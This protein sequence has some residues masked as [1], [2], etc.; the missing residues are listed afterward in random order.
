MPSPYG[1]IDIGTL[2][3]KCLIGSFTLDEG[4]HEIYSS[5]VLTCFGCEMDQNDGYILEQNIHKTI[6]ELKRCLTLF[7][8]H[9][10]V[11]ST[12]VATHALRR[13]KN[14]EEITQ[15]IYDE[16]NQE[17]TIISPEQ[18]A[19]LFFDAVMFDFPHDRDYV[20]LDMGGGSV[21]I[22]VGNPLTLQDTY[23]IQSGAQFLHDN[24]TH[25]SSNPDSFTTQQDHQKIKEYILD[26][27]Q[28]VIPRKGLPLVYGSSN[29]IDLMKHIDMPLEGYEH[30]RAHPHKITP[31]HLQVFISRMLPLPYKKREELYPFQSGYMWGIDKAF[32]TVLTV[33]S[34]FE[35]P[36][37]IPSNANIAKGL[38]V[39]MAKKH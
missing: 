19:L 6:E 24:F 15:R 17:V 39:K 9:H 3:V 10:V 16:T 25:D 22:L 8:D 18:E 37:I 29:I 11:K 7:N 4:F 30:S 36:Y 12:I 5:N 27:L 31:H 2:K 34:H 1:I 13:A 33:V 35:S 38:I 14:R 21:Q 23:M 20:V 28:T 26:T 32:L